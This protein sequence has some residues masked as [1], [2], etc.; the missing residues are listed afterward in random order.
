MSKCTILDVDSMTA[1]EVE[2]WTVSWLSEK[3]SIF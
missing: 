2:E 1:D 3:W